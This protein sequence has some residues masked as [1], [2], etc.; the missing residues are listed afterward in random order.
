MGKNIVESRKDVKFRIDRHKSVKTLIMQGFEFLQR[1][2][3][4]SEN[5]QVH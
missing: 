5:I 3:L 1:D 2:C 4:V